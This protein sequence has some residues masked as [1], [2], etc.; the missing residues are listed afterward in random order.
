MQRPRQT[1]AVGWSALVAG[2]LLVVLLFCACLYSTISRAADE[3]L[4]IARQ[5]NF[6][7]GGKYVESN[8]DM[9]MVGQAFVEFQIPQRQ[10]QP[11]PIVMVHGGGQ[12]GSGWIS[13]PDGR[14][15]WAQYFLRRG[16]AIYVVDQVARGRS[17]YIADVYGTSRAQTREY[18]MQRFSTMEKYNLWP[19]AKLHTQWPDNAEPG[20][21]TF[22][23]YFASNVPSM[24]NRGIQGR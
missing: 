9:P 24:E 23:N 2:K 1:T 13:T 8:G 15:G 11:Y 10:T 16:Y 7:V 21:P 20:N 14:E 17:A 6:Y 5:G 22:D 19:Q 12:T 3:P 4:M 18:V